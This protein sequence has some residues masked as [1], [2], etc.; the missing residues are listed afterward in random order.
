MGLRCGPVPSPFGAFVRSVR[1]FFVVVPPTH[2][3]NLS[4][5]EGERW[6]VSS[7]ERHQIRL[8]GFGASPPGVKSDRPSRK[9]GSSEFVL[10]FWFTPLRHE[11]LNTTG[12]S[13]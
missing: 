1:A 10:R 6:P 9:M 8:Q 11:G 7:A 3:G 5:L 2:A 4:P 12:V 13:L